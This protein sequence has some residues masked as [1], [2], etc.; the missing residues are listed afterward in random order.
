MNFFKKKKKMQFFGCYYQ[1]FYNIRTDHINLEDYFQCIPI[2][3]EECLENNFGDCD[4]SEHGIPILFFINKIMKTFFTLYLQLQW[5][6]F[7]YTDI[8]ISKTI[9]NKSTLS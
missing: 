5:L 3:P 7:Y 2:I 1:L 9:L 6:L 8:L 4:K